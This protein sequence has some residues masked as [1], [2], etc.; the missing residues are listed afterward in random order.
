M[1]QEPKLHVLAA[2]GSSCIVLF[3]VGSDFLQHLRVS[4]QSAAYGQEVK[5]LSPVQV[6]VELAMRPEAWE[7]P[8]I[9]EPLLPESTQAPMGDILVASDEAHDLRRGAEPIPQNGVE[10]IEVAIGDLASPCILGADEFRKTGHRR[11]FN[12]G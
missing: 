7:S 2:Y 10:N 1:I 9:N 11:I 3:P 5:R 6:V 4:L 12:N 8:T